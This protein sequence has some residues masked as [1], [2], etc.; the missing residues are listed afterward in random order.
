M[1]R[2]LFCFPIYLFSVGDVITWACN[3]KILF[4]ASNNKIY[5]IKNIDQTP[6]NFRIFCYRLEVRQLLGE[7]FG[8]SDRIRQD[9]QIVPLKFSHRTENKG[10]V[11]FWTKIILQELIR[12]KEE[13]LRYD[14]SYRKIAKR[15]FVQFFERN[16][17]VILYFEFERPIIQFCFTNKNA[18]VQRSLKT[19]EFKKETTR[20]NRR[21]THRFSITIPW[22]KVAD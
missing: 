9:E 16:P 1:S 21:W 17:L 13:Q 11:V 12:F 14:W 4:W 20:S 15:K 5:C 2:R 10:D 18:R 22:F 6:R 8:D 3:N 19:F 7:M